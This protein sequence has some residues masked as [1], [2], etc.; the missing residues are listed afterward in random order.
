MKRITSFF[1]LLGLVVISSY[2]QQLDG[3]KKLNSKTIDQSD[4]SQL[5]GYNY[6]V[7]SIQNLKN[8]NTFLSSS[9]RTSR[10]SNYPDMLIISLAD[11]FTAN[12]TSFNNLASTIHNSFIWGNNGASLNPRSLP[13]SVNLSS[14]T[15]S[16]LTTNVSYTAIQRTWKI[17]KQGEL[18]PKLN[19]KI[20]QEAIN[21]ASTLGSYYM[22]ISNSNTFDSNV[23]FRILNLDDN[24][25]LETDY[26]FNNS[27]YITFG[28]SPQIAEERAI[29]FN[30]TD[31]YIDMQNTLDLNPS[32]FTI[33]AWIKSETSNTGHVSILSKRD[34]A[35]TE[36][37]DLT[38]TDTNKI[39]IKWKNEH[40]Q[41][42]TSFTSIPDNKWH[43]IAV[44]YDGSQVS[45]FIDGVLDNT[46]E[47]T[48]PTATNESFHIAAAGKRLP[49]QHFKG[50]IDE[51]QIW[52]TSLTEDQLRYIMNQ[53]IT[54]D[55]GQVIGK[56]LPI[57]VS[58][59]E[60]NTIPWSDLAAYYPMSN[61]T[62]KNTI[63]ASG[64]NNNGYLKHLL[65]VDKETAPLPYTS[66]QD[67]DWAA[68][69]SWLN[70][71]LQNVPGSKSIV[72][73][74][75]TI[76]WN[77]V[78]TSHRLTMD[79][80]YLP[81]QKNNNRTLLGL[82]VDANELTLT[83]DTE[84]YLGNGLTI[85]HHLGLTGTIDL[86]GESQL[87]QTLGS[88]LEVIANGKIE[89]DQQG[90][91][92][93]YTYNYWSSPVRRINSE[94]ENF[95]VMDVLKDGTNPNAPADIQFLSSGYNGAATHPIKIADYW[96]WKYTNLPS[97]NYSAWQHIRRTGTILPGEGFTMKGPGTGSVSSPQ[98]YVFSGKPNNGDIDL[99]LLSN[100]DY[101]VGNPYPS[102]IDALQFI[103]DNGPDATPDGSPLISGTL[104]FWNHWGGG[105]H[106]AQDYDGG[107]A[108]YNF[109][110]SVAAAY[111]GS[112]LSTLESDG[113]PTKAP[114]RHIPVGQ[115][116]F[117]IGQ[118][119]GTINFNNGQRTF[120][121]EGNA[122]IFMRNSNSSTTETNETIQTEDQR[123]KFRIGFNSVNTIRRQLL[124]T[125][126][127]NAS[128]G[129]DWAYDGE[130]NETQ[131]D[132]M[133]WLINDEAYII[134]ASNESGISA[135]YP[136]GIKT[137]T[138]GI[139]SILIDALENVPDAM[140]VYLH[141]N[142]LGIYHDLRTGSY[143]I[144]LIKGDYLNRFEI[145][146]GTQDDVLGIDDYTINPI[147]VLYSN[148][149]KKI[150]VVNPNQ[151]DV[152][153]IGVYNMLGQSVYNINTVEP[154][155]YSEYNIK[156]LSTGTYVVKLQ[157]TS[158][159]TITKKF[160]V[161]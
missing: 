44:T 82:F 107:Y 48:A 128:S 23:D 92:D 95:R 29:Y 57:S 156:N 13:V 76:D 88:D 3:A 119:T 37:Y 144:F 6:N 27:S 98:N 17:V 60:I 55:S 24:G 68:D 135:T 123:M 67:G 132:D 121:K 147:D 125:I 139:N 51:V 160:I 159:F 142:E 7:S 96:I 103:K 63:D 59:N 74:E 46:A 47:K 153:M 94:V 30:G 113:E 155:K 16:E 70:G 114:Q 54:N 145:T 2:A 134:Q 105:T 109:S 87:I 42:L 32:G 12:T 33:S 85:T 66:K 157:T 84:F 53:E 152:K 148:T 26:N 108:T 138:D 34:I 86:E 41:S 91:A 120:K 124:L 69:T 35:F 127:E 58:K 111:K 25:Y 40:S 78:R 102:A 10:F 93:T 22:L 18:I 104:Y 115:G 72:N 28:F 101:L 52:N 126:D 112:N 100:S 79:N 20:P 49:I 83:G 39:N 131:I 146:F 14:E 31:S 141:D 80:T 11:D 65:T 71:H 36:G 97:N 4:L 75:E 151:I 50:H 19:I 129:V 15:P 149:I 140:N 117:V 64:N 43:H 150:V 137:K 89:R 133:F 77:I 62:Y 45:I 154:Q 1:Y 122:S 5:E 73:P 161:D 81:T 61:F 116:F 143:D 8:T 130:I 106:A 158:G 99:P 118:N 21:N 136:L 9:T 56:A 90:T 110:G 38:L